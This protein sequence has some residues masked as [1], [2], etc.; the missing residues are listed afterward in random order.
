MPNPRTDVGYN[1]TSGIHQQEGSMNTTGVWE[2]L[3]DSTFPA[4][5]YFWEMVGGYNIA[6]VSNLQ[7]PDQYN[8]NKFTVQCLDEED[9]VVY[10]QSFGCEGSM[11]SLIHI[12]EPTRRS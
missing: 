2:Y 12:S 6:F 8:H 5:E 1:T 10:K 9:N 3:A 11:L 7:A 4:G